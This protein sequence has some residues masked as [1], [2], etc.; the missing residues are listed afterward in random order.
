MVR[1]SRGAFQQEQR[2]QWR[3]PVQPCCSYV[4]QLHRVVGFLSDPPTINKYERLKALLLEAFELSTAERVRRLFD[5]SDLGDERPSARMER[6]LNLLGTEDPMIVFTELF[7]RTLPA[8]VRMALANTTVVGPRALAREADRFVSASTVPR[9][10]C[11]RGCPAPGP[12]QER[13]TPPDPLASR[14][15][16]RGIVSTT[17]PLAPRPN[18]AACPAPLDRRET[19]GPAL[20]SSPERWCHQQAALHT[21]HRLR[22]QIPLWHRCPVEHHSVREIEGGEGRARSAVGGCAYPCLWHLSGERVL[23]RATLYLGFCRRSRH[24][25]PPWRRFSVHP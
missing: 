9:P 20:G 4:G 6:M 23:W 19:A 16:R 1:Y 11:S 21:R 22:S 14:V 5:M 18:G 24:I 3:R 15:T 10:A 8:Q 7:M 17:P 25:S 13:R 12:S 2:Y